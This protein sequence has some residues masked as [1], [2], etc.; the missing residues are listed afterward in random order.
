MGV[1]GL[2]QVVKGDREL[3]GLLCD[4]LARAL[5][6]RDFISL[7]DFTPEELGRMLE[8]A[9]V[10]KARRRS[11]AELPLL[12]GR[13]LAM[14][15]HKPST[16]TRL[17]FE[18]GMYQLGGQPLFL[19]SQELQLRRGETIE[20]TGRV[21]SR[22]V[23]GIMIRTFSH[24]DVLDLARAAEVPVINGLTDYLH[25]CQALA[26]YF[27]IGEKLGRIAGVRV[28]YVG[29]G[30]NVARSLAFG[31]A[32][33]GVH[34]VVASPPAYRLDPQSV[35]E[36]NRLAEATGATIEL[37]E[38]PQEAAEGAEV[39]YTDVWASMGQE[40]E[41][42]QRRRALLPYQL[43]AALLQ[44]ARPGALVMHC[45]PAHRG[46]EITDE[47]MDGP[48]SVVF[49]QAE[50]RLHVQKALL[51]LLLGAGVS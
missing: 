31:A 45:L 14:I 18:V 44:R 47:V 39:L 41:H 4:G 28:A 8:L 46:E 33:F 21:L 24:Q 43:N 30:N 17:S 22:Y 15:F 2:A 34:L 42:D 38:D 37:T 7:K 48:Q 5:Q 3:E 36:A 16:R 35:A 20:D 25:P 19:S 23:D 50:N 27:T 6:G 40:S 9:R 49:D 13:S 11:R 29:D 1:Q 26:D 51:A 32:R 10:L 12:S